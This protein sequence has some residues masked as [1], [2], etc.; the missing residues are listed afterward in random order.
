MTGVATFAVLWSL[1]CIWVHYSCEGYYHAPLQFSTRFGIPESLPAERFRPIQ[2]DQFG[3]DG[4]FYYFT[5]T[6]PWITDPTVRPHLDS[7]GYRY[8]R[9][10]PSLLVWT[11][12]KL[13]GR[14]YPSPRLYFLV[15]HLILSTGAGVLAGFL[16]SRGHS[17]WLILPWLCSA[18][19][20]FPTWHGLTDSVSDVW[21]LISFLALLSRRWLLYSA[22][23]TMLLLTR[24][25]YVPFAAF[26]WLGLVIERLRRGSEAVSVRTLLLTMLPGVVVLAWSFYVA[27]QFD[28][29]IMHESRL[30][31]WGALTDYPFFAAWKYIR[32]RWVQPDQSDFLLWFHLVVCALTLLATILLVIRYCRILPAPGAILA[33]LILVSMTGWIVW[34]GPAGFL[35]TVTGAVLLLTLLYAIRPSAI[36]IVILMA[37]LV[38]GVESNVRTKLWDSISYSPNRYDLAQQYPAPW[39][40]PRVVERLTEFRGRIEV[41]EERMEKYDG[42]WSFA[43]V[44]IRQYRVRVTNTSSV[45]WSWGDTWKDR[46][47]I[48]LAGRYE[49][50]KANKRLFDNRYKL[51]QDVPPGGSI[52]LII[53]VPSQRNL[54]GTTLKLGLLQEGLMW[55]ADQDPQASVEIVIP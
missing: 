25:G 32:L 10:G 29:R 9:I 24:E 54:H 4:Q 51:Y 15:L 38:M 35:K 17:V 36:I 40:S 42:F 11:V 2:V 1:F 39:T 43:H 55:F 16:S 41:L 45:M 13:S 48:V 23:A 52:E 8:Q 53:A 20:L 50:I 34:E 18:G 28:Q 49:D 22:F 12:A 26:V 19:T 6:D 33:W 27:H 37:N 47:A 5:S 7:P 30:I 14:S 44:P 21:F 46:N 31:S 3:W